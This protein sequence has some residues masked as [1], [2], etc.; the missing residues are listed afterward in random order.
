M[1][2]ETI[3]IGIALPGV[4]R[5]ADGTVQA[6]RQSRIETQSNVEPRAIAKNLRREALVP[7]P[8]PAAMLGGMDC[9]APPLVPRLV[10]AALRSLRVSRAHAR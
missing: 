3:R 7:L 5:T 9:E 6:S 8:L 1:S 2:I 10:L 4:L